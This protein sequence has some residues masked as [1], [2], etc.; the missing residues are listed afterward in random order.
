MSTEQ[1]GILKILKFTNNLT[2]EELVLEECGDF[3]ETLSGYFITLPKRYYSDMKYY[4]NDLYGKYSD[5]IEEA[6]S[7]SDDKI[8]QLCCIARGND[9]YTSMFIKNAGGADNLIG[10]GV[11]SGFS[12]DELENVEDEE[13]M[14]RELYE[15]LKKDM[16]TTLEQKN[17]E[18]K[19]SNEKINE[20]QLELDESKPYKDMFNEFDELKEDDLGLVLDV[21]ENNLSDRDYNKMVFDILAKSAGDE[22][23]D[24]KDLK[25]LRI[26]INQIV[27]WLSENH[28]LG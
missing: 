13:E 20:L 8:S 1:L 4:L 7:S 2:D 24:L 10:N 26:Y 9:T 23:S 12:E 3:Y 19:E 18:L 25:L 5:I 15:E 28:F 6:F 27:E 17:R 16:E 11:V 14:Y 21:M 22:G